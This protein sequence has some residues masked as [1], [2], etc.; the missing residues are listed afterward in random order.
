MVWLAVSWTKKRFLPDAGNN[1][2][3]IPGKIGQKIDKNRNNSRALINTVHKKNSSL[4]QS[5]KPLQCLYAIQIGR[6]MLW[7][8]Q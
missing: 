5:L 7:I 8:R 2:F 6:Q 4:A 1:R 3:N